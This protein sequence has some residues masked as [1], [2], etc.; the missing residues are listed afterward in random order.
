MVARGD[1]DLKEFDCVRIVQLLCLERSYDGTASI[2]RP[3]AIGD[4]GAIVHVYQTGDEIKGYIVE[5]IDSEGRTIWLA[6]FLPDE[7]V[8]AQ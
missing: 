1:S 3:P 5:S 7:L 4:T 8:L 6:D 2:S